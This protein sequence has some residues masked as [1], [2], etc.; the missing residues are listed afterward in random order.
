MKFSLR[1]LLWLTLVVSLV[2]G[3]SVE[4]SRLAA[5]LSR[6]S[7][8]LNETTS[9]LAEAENLLEYEGVVFGEGTTIHTTPDHAR[10]LRKERKRGKKWPPD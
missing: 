1:D 9:R 3:W 10:E 7:T 8:A 5:E 2:A 6:L 4:H